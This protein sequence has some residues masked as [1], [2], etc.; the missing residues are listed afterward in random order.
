MSQSSVADNETSNLNHGRK[1]LSNHALQQILSQQH[2]L[3]SNSLYEPQTTSGQLNPLFTGGRSLPAPIGSERA[4]T[5]AIHNNLSAE[6]SPSPESDLGRGWLRHA[7]NQALPSKYGSLQVDGSLE[8]TPSQSLLVNVHQPERRIA[9]CDSGYFSPPSVGG[10]ARSAVSLQRQPLGPVIGSNGFQ[11]RDVS[12]ECGQPSLLAVGCGETNGATMPVDESGSY[13]IRNG[14]TNMQSIFTSAQGTSNRNLQSESYVLPHQSRVNDVHLALTTQLNPSYHQGMPE[15]AKPLISSM[16]CEKSSRLQRVHSF[17][18]T[19]K[20]SRGMENFGQFHPSTQA[21]G[22]GVKARATS[23]Q[24]AHCDSLAAS[25]MP[26]SKNYEGDTTVPGNLSASVSD[27]QNCSL[28]ILGLP[29]TVTHHELLGAI[30][31]VGKVFATVINPPTNGHP[32]AAAKIV[33]FTRAS[34][35]RLAFLITNGRF[36][37]MGKVVSNVRWNKIKSAPHP[38]PYESRSIR[39]TGAAHLMDCE[40]LQDF[41]QRR[42]VYELDTFVEYSSH[43]GRQKSQ[44]WHFG[45]LRCQAASAKLAIEREMKDILTVEW[46]PDPCE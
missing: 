3:S 11:L 37:V 12:S 4:T 7:F 18:I 29:A 32:T 41:F 1:P 44:E 16:D 26:V 15:S 5:H 25:A 36:I 22:P 31:G 23:A 24:G 13:S 30:K 43:D 42:F 38:R 17:M 21:G 45:S 9:S 27:D 33:F 46:I 14:A 40:Y 2:C 6:L 34:A 8:A 19:E 20:R 39:I 35:E 28:W 10:Y